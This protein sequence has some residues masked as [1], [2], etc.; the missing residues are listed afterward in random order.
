MTVSFKDF[1]KLDI[2][3]GTVET[4]GVPEW[5]HWVMELTVDFGPKEGKR[6]VF[7]G[8]MK[9]YKPEDLINKQFPFVINI[10]P[11]KIGPKDKT[12]KQ[13]YSEAMLLAATVPVKEK[14]YDER[15]VLFSLSEKVEN[16]SR[17]R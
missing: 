13:N 16:G 1:Q 9:F 12:G 11:K 4:A 7:A 5:S 8:V 3:V 6:K 14:D 17:V 2:R 15:P 10:E